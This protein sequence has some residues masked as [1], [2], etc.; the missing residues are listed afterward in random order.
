LTILGTKLGYSSV[1]IRT[2][3][4][5]I[6]SIDDE[7]R[8][9]FLP[10][11]EVLFN[12]E[13]PHYICEL[14]KKLSPIR[15]YLYGNDEMI[16]SEWSNLMIS[17][18]IQIMEDEDSW[19]AFIENEYI[20]DE[21]KWNFRSMF[22][23]K[24]KVKRFAPINLT[25]LDKNL[26]FQSALNRSEKTLNHRQIEITA[27]IFDWYDRCIHDGCLQLEVKKNKGSFHNNIF[28]FKLAEVICSTRR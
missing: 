13:H 9:C 20:D 10:Y 25:D 1:I 21:M 2:L 22:G 4:D 16:S 8:P 3:H 26:R 17:R 11:S 19:C 14:I 18:E 28:L 24:W 6:P 27:E 12:N 23:E 7:D 5:Y 15:L